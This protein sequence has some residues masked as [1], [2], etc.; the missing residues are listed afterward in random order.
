MHFGEPGCPSWLIFLVSLSRLKIQ[1]VLTPV[2]SNRWTY[3]SI[4]NSFRLQACWFVFL[5]S[6]MSN[7]SAFLHAITSICILLENIKWFAIIAHVLPD[8]IVSIKPRCMGRLGNRLHF[9]PTYLFIMLVIF[10]ACTHLHVS[11]FVDILIIF[12]WLTDGAWLNQSQIK[13]CR[14][15]LRMHHVWFHEIDQPVLC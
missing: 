2:C 7:I 4:A 9:K 12:D 5:V 15:C 6:T 8:C 11:T 10:S 1:F 13:W 14:Q 3:L